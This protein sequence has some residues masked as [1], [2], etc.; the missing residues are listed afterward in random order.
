MMALE[1]SPIPALPKAWVWSVA[2]A[3]TALLSYPVA[4]RMGTVREPSKVATRAAAQRDLLSQSAI[5]Y[6]QGRYAEAKRVLTNA[7]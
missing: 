2:L 5:H 7:M 4:R 3:M 6:Q 1:A